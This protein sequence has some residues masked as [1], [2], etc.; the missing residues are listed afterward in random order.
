M[1]YYKLGNEVL[2]SKPLVNVWGQP[3]TTNVEVRLA[4]L[5]QGTIFKCKDLGEV[6]GYSESVRNA[7]TTL[8][9]YLAV[10]STFGGHEVIN[11]DDQPEGGEE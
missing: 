2:L 6:I 8:R 5:L 7:C 9:T 11:F 1:N 10:A 4:Q 3:T